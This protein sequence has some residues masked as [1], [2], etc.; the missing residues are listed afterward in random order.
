M[1]DISAILQQEQDQLQAA[2]KEA[3]DNWVA[4][5]REEEALASGDHYVAEIDK[6]EAADFRADQASWSSSSPSSAA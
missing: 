3:V 5:I 6:W 2:Y 4:A 1:A